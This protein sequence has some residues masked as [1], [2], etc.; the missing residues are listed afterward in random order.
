MNRLR[1]I[2]G[3]AKM[4]RR[5]DIFEQAREAISELEEHNNTTFNT[6]DLCII[7]G[8]LAIAYDAGLRDGK[9]KLIKEQNEL[10]LKNATLEAYLALLDGK[11]SDEKPILGL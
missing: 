2:T 8:T 10:K 3:V 11:Q 4:H 5:F 1:L 9:K 6:F 7:V